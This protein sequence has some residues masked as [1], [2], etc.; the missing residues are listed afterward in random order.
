MREDKSAKPAVFDLHWFIKEK[1]ARM[2]GFQDTAMP[3]IRA[4]TTWSFLKLLTFK[5]SLKIQIW[6]GNLRTFLVGSQTDD[7]LCGRRWFYMIDQIR[8]HVAIEPPTDLPTEKWEPEYRKWFDKLVKLTVDR[9]MASF[10]MNYHRT[11]KI[12][13]SWNRDDMSEESIAELPEWWFDGTKAKRQLRKI[14]AK[15]D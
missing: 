2:F 5:C 8:D 11:G 6:T 9:D 10:E 12:Q 4:E 14:N 7:E 15:Q 13:Y 1:I 3:A